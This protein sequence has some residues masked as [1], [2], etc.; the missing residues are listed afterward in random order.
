MAD[1]AIAK[2]NPAGVLWWAP[3]GTKLPENASDSLDPAFKSVGLLNEDGITYS[4]DNDTTDVNDMDGEVVLSVN[5]SHSET[6]QFVMLETNEESLKLRFGKDNVKADASKK[7]LQYATV[8]PTGEK[9]SLVVDTLMVG[10]D[11][12]KRTVIELANLTD[13]GDRQEHAGDPIQYDVT[14]AIY[15]NSK[16]HFTENYIEP[17]TSTAT[18]AASH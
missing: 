12:R 7:T 5:A 17:L 14:F 10:N 18:S 9:V 4:E 8:P 16:G 3:A 6:V 15:K 13:T 2:K 11:R 1:V